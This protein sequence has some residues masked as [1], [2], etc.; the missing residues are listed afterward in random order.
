M[1]DFTI[2]ELSLSQVRALYAERLTRDFPK[3]ELK[4]L[5]T[6]ESAL[7][8]GEYACLGAV[9]AGGDIMAYAFFA[10]LSDAQG[11]YALL[12]YYAVREDARDQGLGGAFLRALTAGPLRTLTCAL[13][14]IDDP[15]AAPDP[16]ELETRLR[17]QRFY[18]RNGLRDTGVRARVYGADFRILTMPLPDRP[19]APGAEEVRRRYAALYRAMLPP[20][21]YRREFLLR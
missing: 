17:R 14:E 13:V 11:R 4:P 5:R 1:T 6:I 3:N 15:D 2:H 21:L 8:R 9:A 12:D 7:A 16:R 18:A 19:D 10:A 20:E